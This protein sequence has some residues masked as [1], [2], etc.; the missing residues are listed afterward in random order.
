MVLRPCGGCHKTKPFSQFNW[1]NKVLGLKHSICRSCHA[2]Y[3]RN[4]YLKNRSRYIA[5]AMKW[6]GNQRLKLQGLVVAHLADHPCIDCGE[7]DIIVLDFDH[8]SDKING[9]AELIQRSCS[10]ETLL[11]EIKKCEVRCANCHRRKTSRDRR[12]WKV[13]M[14]A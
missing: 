5:K 6:N 9:I 3:K 7:A 10:S 1:K 2:A 11:S 14:G 13:L 12:Y 8:K 4:H